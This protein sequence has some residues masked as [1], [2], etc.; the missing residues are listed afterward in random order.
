[1]TESIEIDSRTLHYNL[2]RSK[3]KTTQ[4][5]IFLDR[6][7]E[8]RAPLWAST[9]EI[10]KVILNKGYWIIQ[11]LSEFEKLGP[12]KQCQYINGEKHFYLGKAYA[13]EIQRGVKNNI[14]LQDSRLVVKTRNTDKEYI[15]KMILK[16]YRSR[17]E[18]VLEKQLEYGLEI[19]EQY[20]LARP[21]LKIRK[22]KTRW[23]SCS[24]KRSITL[25]E[26]LI[27]YSV[28][29]IEYVVVHELAHLIEHN[30]SKK[31]YA[32]LDKVMPDWKIRQKELNSG[33]LLSI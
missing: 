14:Y 26:E 28:D 19:M 30:H 11:K 3:R 24:S 33:K 12:R 8:V 31:F 15:K 25:N 16:W 9:R 23:G 22:M 10:Q 21:A 32:I 29:H 17:A 13:L 5:S 6:R 27:K 7:I 4:I 20:R 1:M 18:D 2:I